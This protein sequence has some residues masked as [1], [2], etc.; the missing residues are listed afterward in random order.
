M[1]TLL[2]AEGLARTY[3][4]AGGAFRR[5]GRPI[6][7]VRNVSF[8]IARG[9]TLALVGESGC[10]KSTTARLALGLEE[11]DRGTVRF[12]GRDISSLA[13]AER[14]AFRR[15]AQMVFQDPVGSLNPRLRVG[16]A[17]REPLRVH[18][19]VPRE[20]E[21]GRVAELLRRVGL[22]PGDARR[23][24]HE[25]SG[26]QR[27]RIG[28]ARALSV[29]PDL[30][31]AD[32][33]VS[34]LDVSVQAQILNLLA[35]LQRDLGLTYLFIAHDL[36]VVRH[37]ADRVAVMYLGRIVETGPA[38]ELFE[39]PLHPYTRALL[40]AVPRPRPGLGVR[41]SVRGEASAAGAAAGCPFEPR[42]RHLERD[43]AC[44][45]D[46]PELEEKRPDGAARC[47]KTPAWEVELLDPGPGSPAGTRENSDPA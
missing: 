37:V 28:I 19:I 7:A 17:L 27:Q 36:A 15:R 30:L 26:G 38:D 5:S 32:E 9:E 13:G 4:A 45:R 42:C 41:A 11:P 1:R 10:G 39:R 22:D 40:G 31:V 24:P 14:R 21:A 3:A 20:E 16:D 34:A 8:G 43:A 12:G 46:V 35:A 47:I 23:Y 6:H 33:P 2:E 29:E 44:R 25:F 18:G